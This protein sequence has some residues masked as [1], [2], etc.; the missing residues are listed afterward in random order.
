VPK[1]IVTIWSEGVS[2]AEL[3]STRIV[4]VAAALIYTLLAASLLWPHAKAPV[5]L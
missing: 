1:T 3:F 2:A 4:Y 5:R